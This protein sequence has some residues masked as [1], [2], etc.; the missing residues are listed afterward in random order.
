MNKQVDDAKKT[1]VASWDPT[2][3]DIYSKGHDEVVIAVEE[4]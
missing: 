4:R 3:A 1:R 2:K